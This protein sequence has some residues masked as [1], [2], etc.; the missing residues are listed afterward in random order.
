[1]TVLTEQSLLKN[2]QMSKHL[3]LEYTMSGAFRQ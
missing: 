2:D 1:M 3:H